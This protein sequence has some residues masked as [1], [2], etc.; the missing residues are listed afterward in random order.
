MDNYVKFLEKQARVFEIALE[1][2]IAQ[3]D[4]SDSKLWREDFKAIML[5]IAKEKYEKENE[6]QRVEKL[7]DDD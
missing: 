6:L 2:C 7:G 5:D 3:F 1:E 4:Y